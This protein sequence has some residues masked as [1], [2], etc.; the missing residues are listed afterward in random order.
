ML[1]VTVTAAMW[2][3]KFQHSVAAVTVT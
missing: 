1:Q 2:R 3:L